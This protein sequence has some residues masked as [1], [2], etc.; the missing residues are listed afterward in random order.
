MTPEDQSK[1]LDQVRAGNRSATKKLYQQL[2]RPCSYPVFSDNGDVEDAK[3]VFQEAF[4]SLLVKLKDPTFK[5]KSN[6]QGYLKQ[7]CF[8]IWV[9]KKRER[10]KE[11]P[12]DTTEMDVPDDQ[13]DL[14]LKEAREEQ[15][16]QMYKCLSK[17]SED[18]QKLLRLFFYEKKRDKEIAEIMNY[19]VSFVR[20]KRQRCIKALRKC[21]DTQN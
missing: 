8:N 14:Q 12:L 18:C 16:E 1:L 10:R 21:M 5:V 19:G 13:D 20:N 2:F 15:F 7:A 4:V 17:S 3:E 11:N 6:L 9:K